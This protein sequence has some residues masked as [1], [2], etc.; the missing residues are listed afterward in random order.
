MFGFVSEDTIGL[1]AFSCVAFV[2]EKK[3]LHAI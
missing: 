1:E 3:K 2:T